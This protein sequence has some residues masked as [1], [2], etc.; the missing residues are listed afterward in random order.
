MKLQRNSLTAAETSTAVNLPKLN[1]ELKNVIRALRVIAC[2]A[3]VFVHSSIGYGDEPKKSI[4]DKLLEKLSPTK[5]PAK[6]TEPSANQPD[7]L[8]RTVQSMRRVGDQLAKK[9]VTDDTVKLQKSI[10]DD[11]DALIEKLKQP[12]PP[13]PQS[14]D[15]QNQSQSENQ[16]QQQRNQQQKQQNQS[17]T[18]QQPKQG[19]GTA[20]TRQ[21]QAPSKSSESTDKELQRKLD[22]R[23][24]ELA[25]RRAL[26]NEVWGHLPPNVREKLLN[27]GSEKLL[28]QY[29]ELIRKYYEALAEPTDGE[30][31]NRTPAR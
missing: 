17:D 3:I 6:E 28:P 2:S 26:I 14:Q 10:I 20:A 29:E 8:D 16:K 4:D 5:L 18:Q 31:N 1:F 21:Q 12:P 24:A 30:R 22:E 19:S 13:K 11:I 23:T 15:Q 9:E 25:R 7:E 27:V